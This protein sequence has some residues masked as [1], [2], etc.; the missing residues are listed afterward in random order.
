MRKIS[1]LLNT[2]TNTWIPSEIQ[3]GYTTGHLT[4]RRTSDKN[5]PYHMYRYNLAFPINNLDPS[6]L[7]EMS[8]DK[9][10]KY[11]LT[12]WL[13]VTSR[14]SNIVF[15]SFSISRNNVLVGDKR[16]HSVQITDGFFL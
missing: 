11:T 7:Q 4:S 1:C 2:E 10:S 15:P 8:I 14:A 16:L 6:N 3:N 13:N 12:M 9:N 5:A